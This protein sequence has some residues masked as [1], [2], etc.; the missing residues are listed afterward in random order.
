MKDFDFMILK[1]EDRLDDLSMEDIK[2]GMISLSA[3]CCGT[4]TGCN[5]NHEVPVILCPWCPID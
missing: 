4:N 5:V 3:T 2:G 1:E